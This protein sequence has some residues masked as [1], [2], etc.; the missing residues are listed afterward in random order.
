[1]AK[2]AGYTW[3]GA[4]R[5]WE[6]GTGEVT[7]NA[8]G[9]TTNPAIENYVSGEG[10]WINDYLRGRFDTTLNED[11]RR[12]LNSLD[13]ATAKELGKDMVLYRSVDAK[14]VFG[15][16][17]DL[18]YDNL[19]SFVVY[20]DNQRLVA[21]SAQKV[22]SRK[23]DSY[24]EKGFMSTSKSQNVADEW[25]GFSGSDMPIVMKLTVSRGTR[26]VDISKHRM[27]QGEVILGRNQKV[28][29]GKV[30]SRNGN[31]YVDATI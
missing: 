11:E 17:S 29:V 27:A 1:M 8:N 19:R 20:N 31:I 10:M 23:K 12:Y 2:T 16:M 25:G 30:Y 22:L 13:K 15:N 14:A 3:N 24:V 21:N 28:K 4:S 9:E 6:K 18:E 5:T 26:G 7:Y